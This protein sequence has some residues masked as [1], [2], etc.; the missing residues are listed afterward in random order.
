MLGSVASYG[1][2]FV[3]KRV[4]GA[5]KDAALLFIKTIMTNP[6]VFYDIPFYHEPPYWVGAVCNSKFIDALSARPESKMNEFTRT[7]LH[8]AKEGI[9]KVRT[10]ET[11]ITEP[12]LIR[13]VIYPEMENVFLGK[14]SIDEMLDYLTEYLTA[15]EKQ[16]E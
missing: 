8:A 6:E 11:H 3:S 15:Q 5:K 1:V 14:K 2:F 4:E 7:G 9:P 13:Q 12:V 10:L 16:L